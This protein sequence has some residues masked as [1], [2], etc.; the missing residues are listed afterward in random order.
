MVDKDGDI[1]VLSYNPSQ[2]D[3]YALI[4]CNFRGDRLGNVELTNFPP[5][6]VKQF[7]PDTLAYRDGHLYLVDKGDMKVAITNEQGGFEKGID[8]LAKVFTFS[9]KKRG[10][11]DLAGFSVDREGNI[12]FTVPVL[13]QGFKLGTDG[14]LVAFGERGGAP[15]KF[16]IASGIVSDDQGHYFVTDKL[17]CAVLIFDQNFRFLTQVGYRGWNDEGLIAPSDM[18]ILDNKLYITQMGRRGVSVFDIGQ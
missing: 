9:E 16:N 17:K 10:E 7:F 8:L 5:E 3:K 15:G 12:L 14:K 6:F 1:L 13:F 18:A 4:R 2:P 11:M